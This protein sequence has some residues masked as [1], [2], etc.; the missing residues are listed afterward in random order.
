VLD[1]LALYYMVALLTLGII[2]LLILRHFPIS[3][4]SHNE[5]LRVLNEAAKSAS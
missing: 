3:R 5:R 4:E 1:G 2:G